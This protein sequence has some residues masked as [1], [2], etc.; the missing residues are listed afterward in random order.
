MLRVEKCQ[1]INLRLRI[2]AGDNGIIEFNTGFKN[3]VLLLVYVNSDF[4]LKNEPLEKY[5]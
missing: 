3:S 1:E 4:V 5:G 2:P